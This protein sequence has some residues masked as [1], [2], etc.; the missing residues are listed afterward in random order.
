MKTCVMT[1]DVEYDYETE[2]SD[3]IPLIIPRL[4]DYFKKKQITAT[5]FVLGKI[6]EKYSSI[7]Q[8]IAKHHEVASHSYEHI[9]LQSLSLLE[10]EEQLMK[11]KHAIESLGISCDG[12]RAPYYMVGEGYFSLVRKLGFLYDSSIST[13]FPGRYFHV[14]RTKPYYLDGLVELPVPNWLPLFPPAGLSYYRF[15]HPFSRFFSLPYMMY[16]H[17][18][19]FLAAPI[20]ND[21]PFVVRAVYGRHQ[22]EK[23]WKLFTDFIEQHHCRWVSCREYIERKEFI[24][25]S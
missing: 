12:I 14:G 21:L 13:F 5:F 2:K 19:E 25:L 3:S 16:F 11:G 24:Y 1:I 10:Q 22:G 9:A 17:P 20:T 7:I 4:L 18:C 23:A 6:A 15:L 8:E